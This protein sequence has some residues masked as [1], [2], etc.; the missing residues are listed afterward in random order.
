MK[1]NLTREEINIIED[2]ESGKTVSIMDLK[3]EKK[4]YSEYTAKTVRK[5]KRVN[6]RISIRL[7]RISHNPGTSAA[8][9]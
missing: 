4:R 5:D 2:M 8:I 1:N 3:K 6:I 9:E 7:R